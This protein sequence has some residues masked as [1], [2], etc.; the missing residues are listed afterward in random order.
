MTS[1]DNDSLHFKRL[2]IFYLNAFYVHIKVE[3][4][5]TTLLVN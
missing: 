2:M 4:T 5:I 1:C 3:L